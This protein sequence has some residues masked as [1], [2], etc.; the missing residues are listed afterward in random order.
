MFLLNEIP[1]TFGEGTILR[2]LPAAVEGYD[3]IIFEFVLRGGSF[4]NIFSRDSSYRII[5]LTLSPRD[6]ECSDEELWDSEEN[7]SL[8]VPLRRITISSF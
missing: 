8:P 1:A 7:F 2:P 3:G 6:E 5:R 4:L